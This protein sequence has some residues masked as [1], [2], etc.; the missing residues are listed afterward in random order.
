M[1]SRVL[2]ATLL[3]HLFG[4]QTLA[5]QPAR[6]SPKSS[7]SISGTAWRTGSD[8]RPV[9]IAGY[10]VFLIETSTRDQAI[11]DFCGGPFASFFHQYSATSDKYYAYRRDAM[12]RRSQAMIRKTNLVVQGL[13]SRDE[14]QREYRDGM[15][16]DSAFAANLRNGDIRALLQEFNVQAS[17]TLQDLAVDSANTGIDGAFRLRLRGQEPHVVAMAHSYFVDESGVSLPFRNLLWLVPTQ[18]GSQTGGVNLT[19]QTAVPLSVCDST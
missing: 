3:G 12:E 17:Q 14:V 9:P 2:V 6:P 5:Q 11:R 8:G 10:S 18:R 19:P 4:A 15:A 13:V 16:Q 1:C 7:R